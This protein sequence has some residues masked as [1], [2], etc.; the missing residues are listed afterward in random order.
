M[1]W[2]DVVQGSDD[3]FKLRN[4]IP[5]ASRFNMIL[6]PVEGE[7][8]KSQEKLIDELIG[9]RLSAIPPEGIE[10]F[11]NR[12]IRHGQACEEEARRW[13]ALQADCDVFNGG[14]CLTDDDQ[15]GCSPD[16]LLGESGVNKSGEMILKKPLGCLELKCLQ[17]THAAKV[18]RGGVLPDKFR[19]QC[20][21]HMIVTGTDHCDFVSYCPGFPRQ[22][23]V[24]VHRGPDTEKLKAELDRW[25]V[26]FLAALKAIQEA[27]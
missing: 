27:A 24:R 4:G 15:F 14:F 16:S 25:Y 10:H 7:P 8:S 13:Y 6:T 3:W 18:L 20:H 9:E 12:A 21:G 2:F 5:T 1:K 11:T 22:L 19:W 17:P 23:M 26:K